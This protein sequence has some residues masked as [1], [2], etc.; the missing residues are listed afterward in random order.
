MQ[1]AVEGH[2]HAARIVLSMMKKKQK[3]LRSEESN[4]T[5]HAVSTLDQ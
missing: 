3:S 1:V 2:A 4:L 5:N